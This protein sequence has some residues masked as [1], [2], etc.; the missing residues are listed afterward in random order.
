MSKIFGINTMSTNN[1][2]LYLSRKMKFFK[3]LCIQKIRRITEINSQHIYSSIYFF[4][5]LN[6]FTEIHKFVQ[7]NYHV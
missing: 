7:Q 1:K 5:K 4:Y 2:Y 6:G 3:R